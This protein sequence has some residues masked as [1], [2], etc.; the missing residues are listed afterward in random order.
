MTDQS[1]APKPVRKA[2]SRKP[3]KPAGPEGLPA[4]LARLRPLVQENPRG[5]LL[6]RLVGRW[7]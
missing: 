4:L 6:L 2:K 1:T 5:F 7:A 3:K